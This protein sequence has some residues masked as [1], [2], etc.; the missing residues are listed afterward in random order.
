MPTNLLE[1]MGTQEAELLKDTA[2]PFWYENWEGV[3]QD[4]FKG[5]TEA[6][7]CCPTLQF[8]WQLSA[9][10]VSRLQWLEHMCVS[11]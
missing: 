1:L 9:R 6:Q 11:L 8:L 5:S 7:R 2:V 10:S 3:G 4:S